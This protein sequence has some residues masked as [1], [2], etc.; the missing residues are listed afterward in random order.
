MVYRLPGKIIV[1]KGMDLKNSFS[2][3]NSM[4]KLWNITYNSCDDDI[5]IADNL[6]CDNS[7]AFL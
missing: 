1:L 7:R 3:L 5:G 4:F 6:R 2:M